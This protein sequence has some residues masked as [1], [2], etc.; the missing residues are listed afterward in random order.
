MFA[1]ENLLN[2]RNC[3]HKNPP[4]SCWRASFRFRWG[5]GWRIIVTT[6]H[7]KSRLY[8]C[9]L[10]THAKQYKIVH[11]IQNYLF[12]ESCSTYPCRRCIKIKEHSL[13]QVS[14]DNF[15]E[16]ISSCNRNFRRNPTVVHY[17]H[18]TQ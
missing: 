17:I 14:T 15:T 3:F 1:R 2:Q 13:P 12:S 7:N 5:E 11:K 16:L 8:V 6:M 4:T 18:I 9:T 10:H